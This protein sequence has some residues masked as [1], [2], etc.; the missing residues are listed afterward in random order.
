MD[1]VRRRAVP[2]DDG[3]ARGPETGV[4]DPRL[5][6]DLLDRTVPRVLVPLEVSGDGG[7]P[8]RKAPH[9]VAPLDE[10]R[11]PAVPEEHADDGD[12]TDV[13]EVDRPRVRVDDRP[14][15]REESSHVD[16]P[17]HGDARRER[18]HPDGPP[19]QAPPPAPR[20][21]VEA[22]PRRGVRPADEGE[23]RG[24]H[25]CRA[26]RT[27][28][29]DPPRGEPHAYRSR[30]TRMSSRMTFCRQKVGR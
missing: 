24:A 13:G 19:P 2:R 11:A 29:S 4:A 20:R 17:D 9:A 23:G 16:P 26:L 21:L 30:I 10:G 22:L 8:P 28:R 1:D 3:P 25:E 6:P 15:P 18:P 5:L 12:G 27:A 7:P 14:V